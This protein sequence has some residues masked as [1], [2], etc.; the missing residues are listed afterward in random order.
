[1]SNLI[2]GRVPAGE[3]CF[4]SERCDLKGELND[5]TGCP[6]ADGRTHNVPFS[7]AL[8]RLADLM[9]DVE[10]REKTE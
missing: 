2:N 9:Q 4:F 7:C 5:W 6:V 10:E 1:M 3:S 8:A